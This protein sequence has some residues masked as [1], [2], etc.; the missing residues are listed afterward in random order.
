VADGSY[1]ISI[2]FRGGRQKLL[3]YPKKCRAPLPL[4]LSLDSD[5]R[6]HDPRARCRRSQPVRLPHTPPARS[7]RL[8]L[9]PGCCALASTAPD[10]D[11]PTGASP[12]TF[13]SATARPSSGIL[14]TKHA[15]ASDPPPLHHDSDDPIG[16]HPP[17]CPDIVSRSSAASGRRLTGEL[18]FSLLIATCL[19]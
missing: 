13:T 8:G 3:P 15:P 1:V 10:S 14:D 7:P 2:R 9:R 16:A 12:L 6:R 4:S 17:S 11:A 19:L 18:Y 5:P